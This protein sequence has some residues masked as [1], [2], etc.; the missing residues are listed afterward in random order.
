MSEKTTLNLNPSTIELAMDKLAHSNI[1]LDKL[2]DS[3]IET[4]ERLEKDLK[5]REA[6]ILI[7]HE[8]MSSVESKLPILNDELSLQEERI[9]LLETNLELREGQL[10]RFARQLA[11][12]K[13]EPFDMD[14]FKAR[15]DIEY[16]KANGSTVESVEPEIFV[17]GSGN[18]LPDN[19]KTTY[20]LPMIDP[21]VTDDE[22]FNLD[23]DDEMD[24]QFYAEQGFGVVIPDEAAPESPWNDWDTKDSIVVDPSESDD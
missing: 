10:M 22:I 11:S 16:P 13:G 21:S 15:F 3:K 8:E 19:M 5:E 14:E 9:D 1:Y 12:L 17:A 23:I 20:E 24:A 2:V 4:I 7:W 18:D 6:Q